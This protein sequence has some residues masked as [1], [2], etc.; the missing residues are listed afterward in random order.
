VDGKDAE[1]SVDEE[2]YD[3]PHLISSDGETY[4]RSPINEEGAKECIDALQITSGC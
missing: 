3:M 2:T 1:D 4:T